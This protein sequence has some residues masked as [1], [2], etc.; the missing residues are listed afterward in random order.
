MVKEQMESFLRAS[1]LY[2]CSFIKISVI[3]VLHCHAVINCSV[4]SDSLR[5]H[6]QQPSRLFCL[7]GLSRQ[8]YWRGLPCPP[9]GVLP[10]PRIEPRCST[11]QADSLLS[12]PPLCYI[13]SNVIQYYY[14]QLC[15]IFFLYKS[16]IKNF[17][18]F[19]NLQYMLLGK[20]ETKT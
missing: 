18:S 7:W 13:Y 17:Y 6:G 8:E 12:E 1:H 11:L 4:M 9:A 19:L 3:T 20:Y 16:K 2:D 15:V 5:P 14:C 10:N